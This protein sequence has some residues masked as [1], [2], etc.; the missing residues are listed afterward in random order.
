MKSF[1]KRLHDGEWHKMV[2]DDDAR[3]PK[4]ASLKP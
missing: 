2:I 3:I 1:F 4:I